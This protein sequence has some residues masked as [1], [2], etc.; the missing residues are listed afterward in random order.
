MD[1]ESYTCSWTTGQSG[2][3][4]G[5]GV[6]GVNWSAR[7]S[8]QTILDGRG[9]VSTASP[10]S[11]PC[12]EAAPQTWPQTSSI[13]RECAGNANPHP[14]QVAESATRGWGL[15]TCVFRSSP[16]DAGAGWPLRPRT[17]G[18]GNHCYLALSARSVPDPNLSTGGG[19]VP[20]KVQVC[21]LT[22]IPI[23]T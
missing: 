19:G 20:S 22:L 18:Q 16:G 8:F 6:P 1:P 5:P 9:V 2:A 13:T 14:T 7:G 23:L 4:L 10:W 11:P 3:C 15:A 17:L 21:I 12:G